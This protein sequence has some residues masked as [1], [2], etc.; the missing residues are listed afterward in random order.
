MAEP[1]ADRRIFQVVMFFAILVTGARLPA[2]F[3]VG[4]DQ[5]LQLEAAQRL[6][7]G[8]GLTSTYYAHYGS[9]D[10]SEPPI[11]EPLTWWPPGFPLLIAALLKTGLPLL[12]VLKSLYGLAT[13]AG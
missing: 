11:P 12:V 3:E 8:K 13:I 1:P 6:V 2:P 10:L 7:D 5:S 9:H 4:K